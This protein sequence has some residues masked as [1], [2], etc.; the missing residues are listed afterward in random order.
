MG[1]G[2]RSGIFREI[3]VLAG[4]ADGFDAIRQTN[5]GPWG[6]CTSDCS[7]ARWR[8]GSVV[9]FP[10]T[11]MASKSMM[12]RQ[13]LMEIARNPFQMG[14]VWPSSP[15]LARAMARWLPEDS[16]HPIL[17]LGPGTGIVTEELLAAGLPEERLVAVEKSPALARS[18][19]SRF[20]KARILSGDALE[21][22]ELLQGQQVGA[23]FSGLPLKVFKPDQVRRLADQIHHCLLPGAPWVQFSYQL[24]SSRAPAPAFHST[25]SKVVWLNLPPAK[26]SV[27]RSRQLGG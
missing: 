24:V 2:I 13:F 14:A 18:L 22:Q 10:K 6:F 5:T 19:Q 16:H 3:E 20:P 21:I 25:A 7:G 11:D 4:V 23:V 17:E 9:E 12:L 27:Y 1:N 8:G 15:A 26:V